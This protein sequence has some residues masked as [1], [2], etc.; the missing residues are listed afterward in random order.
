MKL[1]ELVNVL[2]CSYVSLFDGNDEYIIIF[3]LG[4]L[5]RY[6]RGEFNEQDM[7]DAGMKH[8]FTNLDNFINVMENDYHDAEVTRISPDED[9]LKVLQVYLNL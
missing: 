3:T 8:V 6:M 7:Q 9:S 4:E 1:C 2:D 5:K